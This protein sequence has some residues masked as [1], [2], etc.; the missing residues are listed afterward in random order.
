VGALKAAHVGVSIVNDPDF[1]TRIEN[2]RKSREKGAKGAAKGG[3][4]K[5][6]MDRALAELREQEMDPTIVKVKALS[7]IISQ[8]A[9]IVDS[10]SF[11]QLGDA[12]IA[13]PF[14]SRR[15]SIDAVLS[16]IRQGRATLV[17]LLY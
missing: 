5:D 15:T 11:P 1:E 10:P 6:R 13:S 2:Q 7:L 14:T 8:V 9:S 16:V 17:N 3:T 12:S 4:A